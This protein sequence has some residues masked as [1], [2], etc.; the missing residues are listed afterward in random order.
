[1]RN[2]FIA[3]LFLIGVNTSF[4]QK[5]STTSNYK[6]RQK[7]LY[8]AVPIHYTSYV[9]GLNEIWYKKS[10]RSKFHFFNDNSQWVQMDKIGHLYTSYQFSH[11]GIKALEWTGVPHK[12]AI[13]FGSLAGIIYQTP[14]EILDGYQKDF[15]ASWG[16]AIANTLGSGLVLSQYLLWN[17]IRI[18]PKFSYHNSKFAKIRPDVLGNKFHERLLKDYNGQTY[19]LSANINSFLKQGNGFPKWLNVAVGYSGNNMVYGRTEEN[20]Q[21]GFG[22]HRRQYYLSFDLDLSRIETKSKFLK[23]TFRIFNNIKVPFP[24][25][26][27]S[28]GNLKAK[29]IYF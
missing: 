6:S 28:N 17:E 3:I 5:D 4:A 2:G 8:I 7:A 1:M 12:K 24:S 9:I 23:T 15:G 11:V 26:E 25:L 19:W 21:N 16:D 22:H 29:A 10:L 27:F 20:A 13:V 14:I 18:Q